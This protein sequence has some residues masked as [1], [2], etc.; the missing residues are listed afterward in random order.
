MNEHKKYGLLGRKLG[1]SLSPKI[2]ELIFGYTELEGEYKLCPMEPDKIE[3]FVTG[4][5]KGGFSGLNV[6]IPYKSDVMKYLA[7]ISEEARKIGS[8]NTILPAANGLQGYNTD[9][10]GVEKMLD[11]AGI[12]PRGK[13]AMVLGSGG[14]ARTVIALLKDKGASDILLVSRDSVRAGAKFPGIKTAAYFELE[15]N[16][17]YDILINTTPVGM[18][19]DTGGCPLAEDVISGFDSVADLIYNPSETVLLK[20]S[21]R[22]GARCVNGLY[23]LVA[24]AVKSQEIWN[25]IKIADSVIDKIYAD[26]KANRSGGENVVLIG[27][28]GSGKTTVG[29]IIA[30]Q[31]GYKFV[32][33]DGMIEEKYGAIPELFSRGEDYFRRCETAC[34]NEAAQISPAVIATGGGIVTRNEN[35]QALARTGTVFF[36]N[37]SVENILRDIV[38]E[39]RPLLKD[40]LGKLYELYDKR[41]NLY[42]EY[43]D[44]IIDSDRELTEVVEDILRKNQG[45]AI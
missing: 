42:K 27:M 24:Q 1:H 15:E 8:V 5:G 21:R 26:I 43:A 29:E 31:L 45:E 32:D 4:I 33:L 38:Q 23:M 20:T 2:H 22:H 41:I 35:M 13:K 18:Y 11:M 16:H 39:T 34:A 25:S 28:P 44:V 7:F 9:Y 36:L 40:G 30:E 19:P 10:F 14:S 3:S 17:G 12:D 6:T 37:R